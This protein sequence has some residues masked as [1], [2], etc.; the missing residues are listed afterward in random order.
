MNA[1]QKQH[2]QFKTAQAAVVIAKLVH[3]K[4]K[5]EWKNDHTN[6]QKRFRFQDAVGRLNQAEKSVWMKGSHLPK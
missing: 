1:H 5:A 3:N 6:D 4:T 2:F